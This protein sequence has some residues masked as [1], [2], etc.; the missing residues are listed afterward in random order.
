MSESIPS[1]G[2]VLIT[3]AARR[4]GRAIALDF[5]ARYQRRDGKVPHEV[6]QAAAQI[7]WFDD[8]PYAYYH[9]DTTPLF[10]IA[11]H[12][13]Y[14]HSGAQDDIRRLWPALK[15]AYDFCRANDSDG[16]GILENSRAGL[17]ASELGSLLSSQCWSSWGLWL[18]LLRFPCTFGCRTRW[19]APRLSQP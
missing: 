16:D 2:T 8:Y 9:A 10:I 1:P 17:G 4:I 6:S 7:R 14:K 3:G 19:K 13:L 12:A 5:A 11:A 18:S 15:S